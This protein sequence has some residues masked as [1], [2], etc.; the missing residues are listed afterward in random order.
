[1]ADLPGL[2]EGAHVNRG[3]GHSFLRHATRC[4]SLVFIVDL[5]NP[6]PQPI[7]ELFILRDE[8]RKYS[9]TVAQQRSWLIAGNK[10]DLDLAKV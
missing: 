5:S 8:L 2:I 6:W 9:S 4:L 7:D 10:I 3:L 1:V